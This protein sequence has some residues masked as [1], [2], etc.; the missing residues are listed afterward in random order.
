MKI[1]REELAKSEIGRT[2]ISRRARRWVVAGFLLL[3]GGYPV[4]QLLSEWRTGSWPTPAS[5]AGLAA[6]GPMTAAIKRCET[7]LEDA[8]LLRRHV[9]P[10]AQR[11]LTTV[12]GTGNDRALPGRDGWLF[13]NDDLAYLWNP[14]FMGPEHRFKKILAGGSPDPAAAVIDFAA[15]LKARGIRLALLPIPVKPMLYGDCFG[16]GRRILQNPDFAEFQARV[17]ASGVTVIDPSAALSELRERGIEPFLKTDTHWTPQGMQAVARLTAARFPG[18]RTSG[19]RLRS[20]TETRRGVGDI[21]R[22]L[23]LPASETVYPSETVTANP[24]FDG[25][26]FLRPDRNSP[27]LL[28]GDSFT[29]IYS[30]EPL[31]W[32]EGAGLAEQLGFLFGRPLDV[33]ARND[34]GSNA[35]RRLLAAELARGRDRLAGKKI[36]I[37]EFVMR[38]LATGDWP[39]IPLSLKP[40][41]PGKFYVPEPGRSCS[42]RATVLACSAVPRPGAAPYKDHIMSVLLGDVNNTGDRALV[43]FRSMENDVWT[44]AARLRPGAEIRVRLRNWSDVESKFGA[45]NRSEFPDAEIALESPCWGEIEGTGK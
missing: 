6:P 31:G 25:L 37:W 7:D 36:V 42:V 3:I 18:W 43:Y 40:V 29:N 9:R 33:I 16:A 39:K 15:Q 26:D 14:G 45:L 2:A 12:L 17:E 35:T 23:N 4:L 24:I 8:S 28:L 21:A 44:A 20:G 34:A 10:P 19:G 41:P 32:G 13:Y 27:I 22:L 11:L 30:F 38:E 1:T 5:V